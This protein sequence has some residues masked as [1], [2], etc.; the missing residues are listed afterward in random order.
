MSGQEAV[1][2]ELWSWPSVASRSSALALEGQART[3]QEGRE[4]SAARSVQGEMR[5]SGT[6]RLC[7]KWEVVIERHLNTGEEELRLGETFRSCLQLKRGRSN[8]K[9]NSCFLNEHLHSRHR[10][11]EKCSGKKQM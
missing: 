4:W 2:K 1:W 11:R 9:M 10:Q 8:K 7:E 6:W 3:V 5:P